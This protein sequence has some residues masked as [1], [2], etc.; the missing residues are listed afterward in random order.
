MDTATHHTQLSLNLASHHSTAKYDARG[1]SP[2]A[3]IQ[4]ALNILSERHAMGES[5]TNPNDM[6]SYLRLKLAEYKNEVFCAIF[7]NARHKLIAY[8]EL[9]HGTID[10]AAVYPRVVVQRAIEHNASAVIFAH[11]HP[12]GVAEPSSAD[13]NITHQLKEALS[14]VDVRVLDHFVVGNGGTTSFAEQGLI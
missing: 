4:M 1:L 10:G 3:I 2:E 6:A 11:N 12:S 7:L 5:F 9:F 13:V 14:L 8:E